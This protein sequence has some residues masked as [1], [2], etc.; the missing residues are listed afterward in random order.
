MN[1]NGSILLID[2]GQPQAELLE[3]LLLGDH[4]EV[5]HFTARWDVLHRL[6]SPV[7]VKS[8]VLGPGNDH[9][10]GEIL[11][12]TARWLRPAVPVVLLVN[13][14][15]LA[16]RLADLSPAPVVFE[17]TIDALAFLRTLKA[18]A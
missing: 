7:P 3:R 1:P 17:D 16:E 11:A 6:A 12:R 15:E 4:H 8:I 14:L 13:T 10:E 2:D 5:E 18:V 9:R